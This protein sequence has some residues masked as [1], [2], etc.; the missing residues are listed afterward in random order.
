MRSMLRAEQSTP[1]IAYDLNRH[2]AITH[3]GG[4]EAATDGVL[5]TLHSTRGSFESVGQFGALWSLRS[6]LVSPSPEPIRMPGC[7]TRLLCLTLDSDEPGCDHPSS[8]GKYVASP[9]GQSDRLCARSFVRFFQRGK[10]RSNAL[11]DLLDPGEMHR[12]FLKH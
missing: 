3:A 10:S 2:S 9:N 6:L 12:D 11:L 4:R 1:F 7:S 8:A 5:G